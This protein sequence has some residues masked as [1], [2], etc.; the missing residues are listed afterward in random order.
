MELF[1]NIVCAVLGIA[2]TYGVMKIQE[3]GQMKM[4][5]QME[6]VNDMREIEKRMMEDFARGEISESLAMDIRMAGHK[7]EIYCKS[8][9]FHAQANRKLRTAWHVFLE[10]FAT[11]VPKKPYHGYG[12]SFHSSPSD[13]GLN[14]K[15]EAVLGALH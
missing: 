14:E 8:R 10:A 9:W 12:F 5:V 2:G 3:R 7:I 13:F 6:L 4:K 15:L 1:V 11:A